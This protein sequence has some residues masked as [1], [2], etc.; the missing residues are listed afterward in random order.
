M[1]QI[2]QQFG[3]ITPAQCPH[4]G[5]MTKSQYALP[6]HINQNHP[7]TD[8]AKRM[9]ANAQR[10]KEE[11]A[12][13]RSSPGYLAARAREQAESDRLQPLKNGRL[14]HGSRTELPLGTVIRPTPHKGIAFATPDVRTAH[15]FGARAGGH[16]YEVE[17]AGPVED[18][19]VRQMKYT[20]NEVHHEVVS[21]HGFRVVAAV[22]APAKRPRR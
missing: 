1:T 3:G 16:T 19:W 6:I 22:P 9:A 12:A 15:D 17:H 13:R 7:E 2:G 21:P 5:A 18:A 8:E 11:D 10:I 14:F 4:C 20:G